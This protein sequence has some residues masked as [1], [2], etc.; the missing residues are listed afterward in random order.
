MKGG[1]IKISNFGKITLIG[2]VILAGILLFAYFNRSNL[3]AQV[4]LSPE[5]I[6]SPGTVQSPEAGNQI[7]YSDA[8]FSP[9]QITVKVG[10]K[11]EFM[12]NSSS[13]VQ[14]NS[15][16]HPTHELYPELNIGVIAPG[17]SKSVSF[18]TTGTKTYH[19]HLNPSQNGQIVVTVS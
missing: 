2:I 13:N 8:G 18:T 7:I 19:N 1:D 3:P 15:A 5:T 9:K 10:E 6:Q 12:N 11:I 17:E 14:V 16:P 4:N